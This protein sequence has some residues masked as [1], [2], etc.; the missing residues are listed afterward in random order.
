LRSK[1]KEG[2]PCTSNLP[3]KLETST[4]TLVA[5][6]KGNE[7]QNN[8]PVIKAHVRE[9]KEILNSP[10]SFSFENEIQK[11]KILVPLLE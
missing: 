1:Q 5:L 9:I 2:K 11:I 3:K 4:K 6:N 7:E 8:Q 10:S